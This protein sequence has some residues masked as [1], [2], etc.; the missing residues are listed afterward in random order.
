MI[1]DSQ[2]YTIRVIT[3][4]TYGTVKIADTTLSDVLMNDTGDD[5]VSDKAKEVDGGIFYYVEPE[6]IDLPKDE[7]VALV[8]DLL[9]A[10]FGE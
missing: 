5:F 8:E 10:P 4:P 9:S 3:T 2:D 6:H 1:F 7:L